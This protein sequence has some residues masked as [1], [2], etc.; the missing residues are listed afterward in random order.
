MRENILNWLVI[1]ATTRRK[2]VFLVS[3]VLTLVSLGLASR[4]TVDM[5]WAAMLP[6][7]MPTVQEFKKIDENYYQPGNMIVAI[8]GPDAVLL[9]QITDEAIAILNEALVCPVDMEATACIE[10]E[11]YARYVY[12]KQ[13]VEW[14]SEHLMRLAKPNDAR[15]LKDIFSDPHLL[16]YLTHLND[17]FEAEYMDGEN[18]KDQEREIV[19]SLDAIQ[20]FIEA[21]NAAAIGKDISKL[22]VE[23]FV[24]D[25][26]IG[27]PYLRSLDKTM[28]L[29]MVSSVV[30]YDDIEHMPMLDKQIE[31]LLA[32]LNAKYADFKIERTGMTAVGRD[33]LDSVGPI[34]MVISLAALVVIFLLLIWNFRSVLVPLLALIPIVVGIIWSLGVFALVLGQLNLFTVMIM[35]IL[36]GLGID[37]SIHIA[38][39][40]HEEMVTGHSIEQALYMTLNETGKGVI[41]GAFTTS[42]AF[43]TLL[44]AKT[45]GIFEFGFCAG[46]GVIVTLIA[47]LWLLPS[48]LV[49]RASRKQGKMA[50][51][52]KAHDFTALGKL[53][54]GMGRW[55]Y[56]VVPIMILATTAG[57]WGGTRLG[58]EWNFNKLEPKGLRSVELQ[59]EII[60][61]FKFSIAFSM[62]TVDSVEVSRKLRK[63]FKEKSLVG[64]V[65]DVSQWVSRPDFEKSSAYIVELRGRLAEPQAP[66]VFGEEHVMTEPR[67]IL[68]E[69][70]MNRQL[71]ADEVDRLWANIVEI[72]ALSFIGGQD[73]VVE[74]TTQLVATRE[75]RDQGLLLQVADTFLNGVEPDL[76]IEQSVDWDAVD[77]FASMFDQALRQQIDRMT[78]GDEPVTLAMV[79]EDIQ[80]RYVSRTGVPEFL[81][82][83][84]PKKNL[85]EREELQLFQDV[86]SKIHPN[87]TG[88]PQMIITMTEETIREG[89]IAVLLAIAVILGLLLLDFRKR[90]LVAG[91]AFLP[92]ISGTALMLGIMWLFGEKFNYVNT[93]AMPVIIGIGVDDGVHF[94]HRLLQEGKGGLRRSATS[95]GRAML[96]TSLTTMIGFGSLMFY[97][98]EG[99]KSM[100]F[101]LFVGVGMC[102]VVTITL[103]PALSVLFEKWIIKES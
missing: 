63:Q 98:M 55:R 30:P 38:T 48:L 16:P 31:K 85:Y 81:M 91:L 18:V 11:R 33:E 14:L 70:T 83:I 62:L 17:D 59:D 12:G 71:L 13:P 20:G 10:Q 6:E 96:M 29:L 40:F 74:K 100:G 32:P 25:L 41:T 64:E 95:V 54:E 97:M 77:R 34:T 22:Q 60:E 53:A 1:M 78:Q 23:R 86:V 92:L 36:L 73:R 90:P 93:I 35:V 87:V 49:F 45:R 76:T 99:M 56:T 58:W 66:I 9:E 65:D 5:R 39:R 51:F 103:L 89:T 68:G 82:Q 101:A 102:F 27:T 57:I 61:K 24:R 15:R 43:Y 50:S 47:V 3:I 88:T 75:N 8:S 4:L 28:G 2:T 79:P 52:G 80:A 7:S 72:Q 37:F 26:T 44:I 42:A 84:T 67:D 46:T 21:L 69:L 94:F 19:S